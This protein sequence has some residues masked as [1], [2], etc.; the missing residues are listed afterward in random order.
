MNNTT[1]RKTATTVS[2]REALLRRLADVRER[3]WTALQLLAK[4][5]AAVAAR[6]IELFQLHDVVD[7]MRAAPRH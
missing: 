1:T 5:D 7:A 2:E 6:L 3:Q 4:G